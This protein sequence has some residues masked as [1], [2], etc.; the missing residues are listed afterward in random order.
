MSDYHPPLAEMRFVMREIRGADELFCPPALE[1]M[2][3]ELVDAVLEEAGKFAGSVL[4]PLNAIG[5]REGARLENGTV[6][7]AAGWKDA[8]GRF[9]EAGWNGLAFDPDWGGQGL[10]SLVSVAVQEMWHAANMG[11]ALCPML[12]QGAVEAILLHGSEEQKQLYLPRLVSGE[13]TGTMCLTEPQAGSDLAAVRTRA[14]PEGDHYRITGQKIF[15]TYGDHDLTPNIVHLVLARTP[16]A[17]PGV[18]GISLF[19]VPK[20]L[21]DAAGEPGPRN[22]VR[23]VSLE[24]KL[25]IHGSPTAV[26]AFG[27]E[28]GAVGYLIG[29]ENRGLGYMFTMMNMARLSVGIQ[30]LGIAERAYQQA[31]AY[32]RDRRQG[33]AAGS[34]ADAAVPIIQHPDVRRML[35]GMK[36]RIEAMRSVAYACAAAADNAACHPD[37]VER[38]R[39]QAL[40]DLLTP[41]VKGWC[42]EWGVQIASTALQVHGGMGYVEETGAAQHYRDARI[43]TIYEGTTGIQAADLVGRKILRDDGEAIGAIIHTIRATLF[44]LAAIP[45]APFPCLHD[46]LQR[47]TGALEACVAWLLEA[48][49]RDAR[50]PQAGAGPF[51]ELLGTVLGG[52][53]LCRSALLARRMTAA[54]EGDESFLAGKLR[55]ARFYATSVLPNAEALARATMEGADTVLDFHEDAF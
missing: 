53:G 38:G 12:T 54:D 20:F 23:C 3:P 21:P 33:R 50:L 9:V 29:E 15:I 13:W 6:I 16:D 7:T 24:H 45:D 35:L 52:Y 31:L 28:E 4:A 37:P 48:G 18:K 27:D 17:P 25:G 10:P 43:T 19:L 1:A 55:A 44:S 8:Y 46:S 22:D 26:L 51:L 49:H 32:A 11:F 5:D 47:G 39:Q 30:G 14:V 2:S 34:P 36:A 42:T 40:V 41:V